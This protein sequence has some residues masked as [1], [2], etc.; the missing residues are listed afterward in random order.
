M[1]TDKGQRTYAI[2]VVVGVLLLG[3]PLVHT[4]QSD[5]QTRAI[6]PG[7]PPFIYLGFGPYSL[8]PAQQ[9]AP[10]FTTND[11][12]WVYSTFN[13]TLLTTLVNPANASITTRLF[14]SEIL[15]LYT[16][17][18][19]SPPG[20][21]TLY[22]TLPNSTYYTVPISLVTLPQTRSPVSLSDYSIQNGEID[23]GFSV[24]PLNSYDLDGC[25][26]SNDSNSNISLSEPA[27]I[28]S[29]GLT[30]TLNTANESATVSATGTLLSPFSFWFELDYPYSYSTS[31]KNESISSEVSVARSEAVFFNASSSENVSLPILSN[32]RT[33]RYVIR[34]YFDSSSGFY[35]AETSALMTNGENWFWLSGCNPFSING[36]VFSEK[37]SL[38]QNPKT[39]PSRLY[40]M[41]QYDGVEGYAILPLQINIAR[42]DFLGQPGNESLSDFT[43]SIS[44]NSDVEATGS[45]AGSIY[46]IART[47][48]LFLSVTPMIGSEVLS[49]IGVQIP[50]AFTATSVFVP[51]G[52]LTVEVLNNSKSDVGASVAVTNSFNASLSSIIPASGNSSFYVP[53]GSYS[54]NVSSSGT[55]EGGNATVQYGSNTIVTITFSSPEIPNTYLEILIVPLILGLGLNVWAWIVSPRRTRYLPKN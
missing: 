8:A 6:L 7:A 3:S 41:Y 34:G 47:Y 52:K 4:P 26:V 51:I 1:V 50:Q 24:S 42:L 16:F 36:T 23:L 54:I 53:A 33:G 5:A 27:S 32:L 44:N 28:G 30:L 13:Q 37:V 19:D 20:N 22:F 40:F 38:E 43:F 12:I 11:S 10:V 35:S 45:F 17:S 9:G 25:L 39:W 55:S 31:I 48:P 29:G 15:S 18:E 14:S 21:W 46:V 2:L 49:S